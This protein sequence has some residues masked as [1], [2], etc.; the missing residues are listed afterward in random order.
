MWFFN[1][2][3]KTQTQGSLFKKAARDLGADESEARFDDAL[4][5]VARH[6]PVG[7]LQPSL[8]RD[9]GSDDGHTDQ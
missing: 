4:K 3:K 7:D 2:S 9:N 5:K 8:D 1:M 6:K